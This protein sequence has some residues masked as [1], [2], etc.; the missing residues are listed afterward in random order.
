VTRRETCRIMD[1]ISSVSG[2]LRWSPI[3]TEISI[4]FSSRSAR[5]RTCGHWR[6]HDVAGDAHA[7][8]GLARVVSRG[9]RGAD[10]HG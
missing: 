1:D 7:V 10:P 9:R 8:R 6:G 4:R 3:E 5:I 2:L